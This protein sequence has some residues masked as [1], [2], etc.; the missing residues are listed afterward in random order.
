MAEEEGLSRRFAVNGQQVVWHD[1]WGGRTQGQVCLRLLQLAA[2]LGGC[3]ALTLSRRQEATEAAGVLTQLH[4][5]D[6]E[7]T[8]LRGDVQHGGGSWTL[9]RGLM[10]GRVLHLHGAKLPLEQVEGAATG[11]SPCRPRDLAPV[12]HHGGGSKPKRQTQTV[13][14]SGER[15]DISDHHNQG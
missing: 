4:G 2:P 11:R 1:R 3:Q 7:A 12:T 6:G 5:V 13:I 9:G 14:R 15:V 10:Q 8:G